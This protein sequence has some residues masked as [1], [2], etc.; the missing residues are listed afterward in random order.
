MG[1]YTL[2]KIINKNDP[3]IFNLSFLNVSFN[4]FQNNINRQ[5]KSYEK[6]TIYEHEKG[7]APGK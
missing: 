4:P 5:I 1:S 6:I 2:F 7:F 3:D